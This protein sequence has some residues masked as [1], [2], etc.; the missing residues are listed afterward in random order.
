MTSAE[1]VDSTHI[2]HDRDHT[3]L[4]SV[5]TTMVF[6]APRERVWERLMF[7]EQID[8]RPPL[9]LRLL[10]PVPIE[11]IGRKSEV[12]DEARCEY[13][14]G[15]L[16]KRVTQVERGRRYEFVVAE[17]ALTVG[18]GMRLS[19]GEY[20]IS[21]LS[22]GRTNVEIVTRYTSTRRPRWVWHPIERAVCHSFHRHILR[23]MRREVEARS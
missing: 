12:G 1:L 2:A 5:S 8:Q 15:Y 6:A 16:I 7:Y 23:A 14:G 21:E 3:R 19:G 17:Q 9:H 13:E 20:T 10:L 4:D 11:T 18:G 22:G